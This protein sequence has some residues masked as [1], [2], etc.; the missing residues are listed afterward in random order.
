[1][2]K[3]L[4]LLLSIT[5]LFGCG[6]FDPSKGSIRTVNLSNGKKL[7]VY[8]IEGHEYIGRLSLSPNDI[9]THSGTCKN[10]NHFPKKGT[11]M[12]LSNG[13]TFVLPDSLVEKK[14]FDISNGT[15]KVK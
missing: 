12:V 6:R 1:M 2:K 10:P 3:L 4:L 15:I 5:F 13:K 14:T 7:Y 8:M 11:V 9:L